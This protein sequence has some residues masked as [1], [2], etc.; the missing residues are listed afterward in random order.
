[1]LKLWDERRRR[2]EA[3]LRDR[4]RRPLGVIPPRTAEVL[5]VLLRLRL[6]GRPLSCATVARELGVSR[7]AIDKHF[8]VLALEGYLESPRS[9]ARLATWLAPR[10]EA[11]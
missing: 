4:R 9:P 11:S 10:M 7:A 8:E 3:N 2:R 5:S 6:E 1:V